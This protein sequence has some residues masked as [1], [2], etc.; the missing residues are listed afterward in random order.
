MRKSRG[1]FA[2]GDLCQR[3]GCSNTSLSWAGDGGGLSHRLLRGPCGAC[4]V[5]LGLH[6]QGGDWSSVL[7]TSIKASGTFNG[8]TCSVSLQHDPVSSRAWHGA[9]YRQGEWARDVQRFH[10]CKIVTYSRKYILRC[11]RLHPLSH[12]HT[13]K[14]KVS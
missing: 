5:G 7:K 4:R 8:P 1:S 10:T 3:T 12:T 9:G 6:P 11:V 2:C 14:V 13:V